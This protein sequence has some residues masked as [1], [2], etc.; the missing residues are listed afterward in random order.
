MNIDIA[1][2]CRSIC[3]LDKAS[4]TC[5]GCGRTLDEIAS[6]SSMDD[7]RKKQVLIESRVRQQMPSKAGNSSNVVNM[8]AG[9]PGKL[10]DGCE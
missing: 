8:A 3:R 10:S 7:D 5:T 6:W 4:Q 9:V 1:S 2:P